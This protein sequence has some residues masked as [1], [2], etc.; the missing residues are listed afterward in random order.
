MPPKKNPDESAA[1]TETPAAEEKP[2]TP[3]PTATLA[4]VGDCWDFVPSAAKDEASAAGRR[5]SRAAITE[6]V[7]PDFMDEDEDF[8]VLESG[9]LRSG[10]ERRS[11]SGASSSDLRLAAEVPENAD[12]LLVMRHESGAFTFHRPNV[13]GRRSAAEQGKTRVGFEISLATATSAN[14]RR[15]PISKLLKVALVRVTEAAKKALLEKL[16]D[17]S[18]KQVID[19]LVPQVAVKLEE[20]IWKQQ[21]RT[22]GWLRVTENALA[23]EEERMIAEKPSFSPG[24]RGLLFIHGTFSCAHGG[25]KKLAGT[26]F[27]KQA[28][29]IYGVNFYA[30]NHFTFSKTPEQNVKEMLDAL[31]DGEFE[32]DVITHSRGGLVLRELMEG[33]S[34]QHPKRGRLKIGRVIMVASPSA[35]TPLA[36]FDTWEK[37]FSYIANLMDMLPDHPFVTGASWLA[38]ALKWSAANLL[39]NFPG[40]TAMEPSGDYLRGLQGAPVGSLYHAVVSNFHPTESLAHRL[41]DLGVD[42][43]FNGAN[44]L[45]VPTEGGWMTAADSAGWIPG[46]RIAC[47]GH[48][49]NAGEDQVIHHGGFFGNAKAVEFFLAVLGDQEIALPP[50]QTGMLL[51]NRGRRSAIAGAASSRGLKPQAAPVLENRASATVGTTGWD[52]E[53]EL[54]LT[55]ISMEKHQSFEDE[56]DDKTSVPML[57]ATYNSARITVPFYTSS[58]QGNAEAGQRWWRIIAMQRY[59]VA[60]ANGAEGS[61]TDKKSPAAELSKALGEKVIKEI[62]G[63][64]KLFPNT[65]F[66]QYFGAELFRTLFPREVLNL[67]N[68]ARFQNNKRSLKIVFSSMIPWVADIP[69][70]L[71]YDPLSDCFLA[72]ADVRF[73]RNVLTP[74]PANKIRPKQAALRILVAS[75]QPSGL[76]QLSIDEEEEGIRNSFK[77]LVEAGLVE[78]DV[79][80]AATA[81]RLHEWLRMPAENDYDVVHFIGHGIYEKSTST[82]YLVF[83]N[84]VGRASKLSATDFLNIVRG[85]NI[86]IVFLNACE[87]GRGEGSNY[88]RGVA[89]ALARDGMPAVVA[90]QYS[91]IDRSTSLFSLHFYSCLAQG[92]QIADAMREARVAIHYRGVEPMDWAVPVLFTSYPDARLCVSPSSQ[93]AARS[94]KSVLSSSDRFLRRS[95]SAMRKT[96]A[97]W[98]AENSFSN[99]QLL[100][101]LAEELNA[102][103]NSFTFICETFASPAYLW[104][105]D[106]DGIFDGV[107]YLDATKVTDRMDRMRDRLELDF[108]FCVTAQPMRNQQG[109]AMYYHS[110]HEGYHEDEPKVAIFSS[111]GLVPA[112]ENL[113]LKQALASH[114]AIALLDVHAK[115]STTCEVRVNDPGVPG[116]TCYFNGERSVEHIIGPMRIP[117]FLHQMVIHQ[118]SAGTDFNDALYTSIKNILTHYHPAYD[119]LST[120]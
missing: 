29:A 40:L 17:W 68:I 93:I 39:G 42:R 69:W 41:A 28:A 38:E 112:L 83:E 89:M 64:G 16:T 80:A 11:S 75:A 108:F 10:N 36:D 116:F 117:P 72:C 46:S 5:G 9:E 21:R 33:A 8:A 111:W 44:D 79:L 7:L 32:F 105:P 110:G 115:L 65:A 85:R 37:R 18:G 45:V 86:R 76:G 98:D 24:T 88:N 23:A 59:L 56:S 51:P 84:E 102:A 73:V 92:L 96:V 57:I 81:E 114:L 30:F 91:V 6:A 71:A 67:Y 31:P 61:M 55:V 2:V 100:A 50:V 19:W 12:V 66:L 77:P 63:E 25:F 49:G 78:V 14:E 35:G 3:P 109:I 47:F 99:R 4:A 97:I 119:P 101:Q 53:S 15:G 52:A 27:F 26:G 60:Y 22:L 87:T 70:E 62:F 106:R 43:F 20:Q 13:A 118:I 74:T 48:G 94:C 120:L 34:A 103:Q 90:N 95:S 107:A 104:T 58:K 113:S 54:K 1:Q 82:G